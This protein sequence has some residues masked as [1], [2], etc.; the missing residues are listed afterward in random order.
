MCLCVCACVHMYIVYSC[1]FKCASYD[2]TLPVLLHVYETS[3]MY[4]VELC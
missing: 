2:C 1:V 3:G 4:G